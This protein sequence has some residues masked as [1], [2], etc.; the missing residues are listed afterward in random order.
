MHFSTPW[1]LLALPAALLPLLLYW[2]KRRQ[3]RR[4][5]FPSLQL[6]R[7]TT[8]EQARRLRIR[9]ILLL[10]LRILALTCLVLAAAGPII[11]S[12][13]LLA[14][15]PGRVVV[16]L[17]RSLSMTAEDGAGERFERAKGACARYLK[18]LPGETRVDVIAFDDRP[19]LVA[20]S[21]GPLEALSALGGIEAGLG[22]T[23]LA[24]ALD[25]VASRLDRLEE[26]SAVALFSDLP[27][28]EFSEPI[29]FGYPL[30]VYPAG[31]RARNG[32]ITELAALNPLPLAGVELEMAVEATGPPRDYRLYVGG[33]EVALRESVTGRFRVGTVPAE[34]GWNVYRLAAEPTDAFGVDDVRRLAIYVHPAPRVFTLGEVGLM[35]TALE[36]APGLVEITEEMGGADVILWSAQGSLT[37]DWES[38]LETRLE[39]GV[40]TMIAVPPVEGLRFPSWMGI[41]PTSH[42][43]SSVGY[44]LGPVVENPITFPLI[45]PLSELTR[46]AIAYAIAAPVLGEDW[47]V[48]LR[49][50][51]GEPAL[52]VCKVHEGTILLWL[53]P[54]RSDDGPFAATEVFS[55]LLLQTIRFC[56]YGEGGPSGYTAGET[57]T[58]PASSEGWLVAPDGE[59]RSCAGE[60]PL[61][62]EL[63][64]IGVWMLKTRGI[65][66]LLNGDRPLTVN[67]PVGEG[68]L[69]PLRPEQFGLIGPAVLVLTE[70]ALTGET[71]E[72]PFPLW[73]VLLVLS[74]IA[75]LV[76]LALA[77][78]PWR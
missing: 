39:T 27:A 56:A 75:L 13:G 61:Q 62:V 78:S 60:E 59:E 51:G 58:I 70:D 53:L 5:R 67:A 68:D 34:P 76:E 42:R 9:E 23:D 3:R 55:P 48:L 18:L 74:I 77:D 36:T 20:E 71:A 38:L 21:V 2:W 50:A 43:V 6:I 15:L 7:Q 19:R 41:G 45:G 30:L 22:G 46:T 33:E 12:E 57:L 73:R 72:G 14:D 44:R 40:G 25:F 26:S 1:L 47:R 29:N 10:L 64:R 49:Y 24:A 17:D 35:E 4:R 52:A 65:N 11:R 28:G 54:Y 8:A 66:P 69:E 31:L 37:A 16:L 63:D 32:G